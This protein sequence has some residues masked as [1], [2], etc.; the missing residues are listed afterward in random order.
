MDKSTKSQA[1]W[2]KDKGMDPEDAVYAIATNMAKK[3]NASVDNSNLNSIKER[4]YKE[5]SKVK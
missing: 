1:R 5:L 4:L 3:Q 2:A